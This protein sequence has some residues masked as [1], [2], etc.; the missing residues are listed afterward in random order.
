MQPQPRFTSYT[1]STRSY[2]RTEWLPE[3]VRLSSTWGKHE[4]TSARSSLRRSVHAVDFENKIV[5]E[6]KIAARQNGGGAQ[7]PHGRRDGD[8]FG[9]ATARKSISAAGSYAKTGGRFGVKLTISS[10]PVIAPVPSNRLMQ[11]VMSDAERRQTVIPVMAPFPP[12]EVT[13]RRSHGGVVPDPAIASPKLDDGVVRVR[14][15]RGREGQRQRAN[16]ES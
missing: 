8:C 15:S 4:E 2:P 16:G 9:Y 5:D 14:R 7:N 11:L 1:L 12:Q 10:I 6:N 13:I 3:T